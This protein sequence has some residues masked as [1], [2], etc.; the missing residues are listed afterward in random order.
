MRYIDTDNDRVWSPPHESTAVELH[1][2]LVKS[3]EPEALQT[4]CD[5]RLNAPSGG[6]ADFRALPFVLLTF[7]RHGRRSASPPP[8][9]QRGL[10]AY[11]EACVWVL[12][13]AGRELPGRLPQGTLLTLAPFAYVDD[14]QAMVMGR[15]L[16]GFNKRMGE[17][18]MPEKPGEPALYRARA[19]GFLRYDPEARIGKIDVAEVE[20][21]DAPGSEVAS[22]E[23][24]GF[25]EASREVEQVLGLQLDISRGSLP[26]VSLKQMR[27]AR[28][29]SRAMLQQLLRTDMTLPRL[30]GRRLL[31]DYEVRLPLSDTAPLARELGLHERQ[32]ALAAFQLE[33]DSRLERSELLWQAS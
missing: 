27:D 26:V 21:T 2:F 16:Y 8:F 32:R 19:A 1:G 14:D 25:A 24:Q 10:V 6:V 4:L 5:T 33:L 28:Q 13:V 31:G 29:P 22:E 23:W 18:L 30:T 11:R 9:R 15:E 20:R 12:V 17:F 7:A 3:V